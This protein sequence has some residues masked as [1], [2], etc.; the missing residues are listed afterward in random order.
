MARG[1]SDFQKRILVLAYEKREQK[2]SHL[3]TAEVLASVYQWPI[4]ER[5][6]PFKSE[7]QHG[8]QNFS[9]QAIG[10]GRYEAARASVSKAF[11]RLEARGLVVRLVGAMALWA[12][13]SL[14][15][16]GVRV[17]QKIM[18][19]TPLNKHSVSQ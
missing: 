17:A 11:R 19:N 16:E 18:A 9:R 13:V 14:T 10:P 3:L 8:R 12:G 6:W 1:L 2:V 4:R 5:G 15:E 7:I